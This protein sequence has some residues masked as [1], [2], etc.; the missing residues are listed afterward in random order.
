MYCK[1]FSLFLQKKVK[2]REKA[3]P[4]IFKFCVIRRNLFE[5]QQVELCPSSA[6]IVQC[7]NAK[8]A[9]HSGSW[10]FNGMAILPCGKI[11]KAGGCRQK[12]GKI[13][14]P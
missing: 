10:V 14:I 5:F 6:Q 1:L 4:G 11:E 12:N 2:G 13:K 9:C 8:T 7:G 3:G